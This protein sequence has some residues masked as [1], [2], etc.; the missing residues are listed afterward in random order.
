VQ[1]PELAE[2]ALAVLVAG[3]GH[4]DHREPGGGQPGQSVTVQP[5]GARGDDG[6]LGLAGGGDGEQVAQVVAAVQHPGRDLS[7]L[8]GL[9]QRRLP[10]RPDPR[11]HDPYLHD[12]TTEVS[13]GD[14]GWR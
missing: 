8:A 1:E 12:A 10:G 9:H 5:P 6:H 2:P 7:R 11:G 4:A 13:G 3:S 14:S